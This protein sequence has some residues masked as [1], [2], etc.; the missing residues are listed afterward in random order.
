MSKGNN[1]SDAEKSKLPISYE[2]EYE[3][4]W[5]ATSAN[6]IGEFMTWVQSQIGEIKGAD[7]KIEAGLVEIIGMKEGLDAQKKDIRNTIDDYKDFV[8]NKEEVED[9]GENSVKKEMAAVKIKLDSITKE[10]NN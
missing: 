1:V 9:V 3:D 8:K 7:K 6:K 2:K 4:L 5:N 10:L